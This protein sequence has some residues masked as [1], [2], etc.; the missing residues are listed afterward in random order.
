MILPD[1]IDLI[2]DKTSLILRYGVKN[3]E[4][5]AEFLRVFSPSAEVRGHGVGNEILQVGKKQVAIIVLEP[6]GNYALKIT[7]SDGH[8][9]GLFTWDYLY[10]LSHQ[11]QDLWQDYLLRLQQAGASREPK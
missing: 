10:Y 3:I 8:D 4:C 11:Q 9:S 7:F 6:I 2:A 5:S 1:E